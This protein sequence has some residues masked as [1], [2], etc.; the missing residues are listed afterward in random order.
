M[1]FGPA[2]YPVPQPDSAT[3]TPHDAPSTPKHHESQ[4]TLSAEAIVLLGSQLDTVTVALCEVTARL[5]D[6]Y[7]ITTWEDVAAAAKLLFASPVGVALV[8]GARVALLATDPKLRGCEEVPQLGPR[9]ADSAK[10][11][12][13]PSCVDGPLCGQMHRWLTQVVA[14]PRV[15]L[16]AVV[17]LSCL[18]EGVIS[19]FLRRSAIPE[20][21]RITADDVLRVA[22]GG[23]V[24]MR[25]VGLADTPRGASPSGT[26]V[27]A[28]ANDGGAG[29]DTNSGSGRCRSALLAAM[30]VSSTDFLRHQLAHLAWRAEIMHARSP[31]RLAAFRVATDV[32]AHAPLPWD[33]PALE[34]AVHYALSCACVTTAAADV[35]SVAATGVLDAPVR[36]DVGHSV[37]ASP[38]SMAVSTPVGSAFADVSP[39]RPGIS[40]LNLMVDIYNFQPMW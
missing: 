16:C 1:H 4:V 39:V 23:L 9:L 31:Q 33:G 29:S 36:L 2:P 18:L 11:L 27:T 17:F 25:K 22:R 19:S 8:Q 32:A 10:P 40:W 35:A 6:A 5:S 37:A 14:L 20:G 34:A 21:S 24:P 13:R 26:S 15:T 38:A 3:P 28:S 30:S 7:K 12:F